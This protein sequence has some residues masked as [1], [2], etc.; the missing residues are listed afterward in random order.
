MQESLTCTTATNIDSLRHIRMPFPPQSVLMIFSF[1]A[2]FISPS[3]ILFFCALIFNS[4][5]RWMHL[6]DSTGFG[7][8]APTTHTDNTP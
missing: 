3:Q 8:G 1:Q 6:S 5:H 7:G 2:E 4:P